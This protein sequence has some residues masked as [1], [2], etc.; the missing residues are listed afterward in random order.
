MPELL[1]DKIFLGTNFSVYRFKHF[2]RPPQRL[3]RY[4]YVRYAT[5]TTQILVQ[6]WNKGM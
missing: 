4:L 6:I 1:T 5:D 3:R 2:K